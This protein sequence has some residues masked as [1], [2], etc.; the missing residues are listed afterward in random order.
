MSHGLSYRLK[1]RQIEPPGIT[2]DLRAMPEECLALA[3]RLDLPAIARLEGQFHLQPVPGGIVLATLDLIAELTR[4]SVVSL[5]PFPASVRE[6]A[7]LRFVPAEAEEADDLVDPEAPDDIPY[8]GDTLDLGAA[9]AEQLALALDP[10]PRRPDE[11]LSP[12][13]AEPRSETAF[14]ALARLRGSADRK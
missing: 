14:A 9:L 7:Q 11:T 6:S 3:A 10:Y 2:V 8:T 12:P 13:A 1:L 5:E 4:I